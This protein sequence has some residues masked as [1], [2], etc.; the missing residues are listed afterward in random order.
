[1]TSTPHPLELLSDDAESAFDQPIIHGGTHVIDGGTWSW[2]WEVGGPV[3]I[4][5]P[6]GTL[7]ERFHV[8]ED[9]STDLGHP[10]ALIVIGFGVGALIRT[11]L[12]LAPTIRT[13]LRRNHAK[14]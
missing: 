3:E 6:D 2:V 10:V 1:M 9:A 11:G 8:H 14:R 4:R 13:L 12:E 7:V 5:D